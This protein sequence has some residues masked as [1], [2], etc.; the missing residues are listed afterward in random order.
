MSDAAPGIGRKLKS[1]HCIIDIPPRLR[2]DDDVGHS[3]KLV[4]RRSFAAT[5][6]RQPLL[7]ALDGSWNRFQDFSY[8]RGAWIDLIQGAGQEGA[9][10]RSLLNVRSSRELREL[11]RVGVIEGYVYA[12]GGGHEGEVYTSEH[13]SC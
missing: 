13:G 3:S 12:M 5:S 6:L 7:N 1:P 4:E 10:Q 11:F 9:R 8:T 2:H